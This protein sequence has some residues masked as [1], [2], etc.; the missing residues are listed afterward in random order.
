MGSEIIAQFS[1]TFFLA[2]GQCN[3]EGML[4]LQ[5]LVQ[6]LIDVAT[7]HAN[8]INIGYDRLREH[9]ASWVLH[10]V[11]ISMDRYPKVNQEFT[12]ETWI[13][14]TGPLSSDRAFRVLDADGN[15][16]GFALTT[17]VAIDFT[18][19]RAIRMGTIFSNGLPDTG[20]YPPMEPHRK[21][22]ALDHTASERKY[23]FC[24]TDLDCNRHVTSRRYVE[25]MLNCIPLEFLDR[26][27]ISRFELSF[28]KEALYD[29]EATV[30]YSLDENSSMRF[31][32]RHEGLLSAARATFRPI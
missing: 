3:A 7:L 21:S 28:H 32:L 5:W 11:A 25:I 6:R 17:W 14:R 10:D 23:T 4:P 1:K 24:Y 30:L 29:E 22:P 15:T 12:V 19:R 13:V 27:Y 31:E 20:V 18:T 26:H 9:G 2:A 8:N 16:I